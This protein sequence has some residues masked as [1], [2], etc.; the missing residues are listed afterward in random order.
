[1]LDYGAQGHLDRIF[2]PR[3]SIYRCP[4]HPTVVTYTFIHLSSALNEH[5][6]W[7]CG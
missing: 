3:N 5:S 4:Y 2:C 7:L 6:N 1:M